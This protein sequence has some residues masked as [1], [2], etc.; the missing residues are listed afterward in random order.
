MAGGRAAARTPPQQRPHH[1]TAAF[2]PLPAGPR[3]WS[4]PAPLPG[5]VIEPTGPAGGETRPCRVCAA[6][7]IFPA[8]GTR[9]LKGSD[10]HPR[11]AGEVGVSSAYSGV[12]G[13]ASRREA[14]VQSPH[15]YL[16]PNGPPLGGY[17][18]RVEEV[19]P[20]PTGPPQPSARL[21][22]PLIGL[23]HSARGIGGG[24]APPS[25]PPS[26]GRGGSGRLPASRPSV[27]LAGFQLLPAPP[28]PLPAP[29]GSGSGAAA[30]AGRCRGRRGRIRGVA[31][32][33]SLLLPESHLAAAGDPKTRRRRARAVAAG[34][35]DAGAGGGPAGVIFRVQGEIRGLVGELRASAPGV[36]SSGC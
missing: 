16:A 29:S 26:R 15:A 3:P 10:D 8:P 14:G 20:A 31:S 19:G 22:A 13:R 35:R 12:R 32:P 5:Y 27:L 4:R 30:A 2:Y 6:T 24:G 23:N 36:W 9:V 17:P 21:L 18:S 34:L 11:A 33:L 25:R 1:P 28:G 7:R